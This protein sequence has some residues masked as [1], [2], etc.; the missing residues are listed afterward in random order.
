MFD[1]WRERDGKRLRV[2]DGIRE[3]LEIP[4]SIV[5][6]VVRVRQRATT[7]RRPQRRRLTAIV[8]TGGPRGKGKKV[9]YGAVGKAS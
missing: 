8:D 1:E 3:A 7:A 6:L 9:G 5:K 2:G 4:I